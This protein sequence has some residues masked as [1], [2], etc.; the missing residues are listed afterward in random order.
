MFVGDLLV[1][2][3][4]VRRGVSDID[5]SGFQF[6]NRNFQAGTKESRLILTR[7]MVVLGELTE[8]SGSLRLYGTHRIPLELW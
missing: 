8:Q 7:S 3:P 6:F 2:D 5:R 4:K 1:G